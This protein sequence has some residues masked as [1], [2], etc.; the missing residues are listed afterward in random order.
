MFPNTKVYGTL[1]FF[2][3]Q[4]IEDLKKMTTS[5]W[6]LPMITGNSIIHQSLSSIFKG[7]I[8]TIVLS[9]IS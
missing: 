5:P 6:Y 2:L 7:S 8:Q 4:I 3:F 1:V 9:L